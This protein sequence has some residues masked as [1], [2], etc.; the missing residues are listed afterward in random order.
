MGQRSE[1]LSA[2]YQ[3]CPPDQTCRYEDGGEWSPSVHKC[4]EE[5]AK[6]DAILF[7]HAARVSSSLE[8][9]GAR[10]RDLPPRQ[11]GGAHPSRC[12]KSTAVE[13]AAGENPTPSVLSIF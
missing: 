12:Q 6:P 2:A 10:G 5:A 8:H 1:I 4:Y 7:A 13:D 9:V 3:A 11:S